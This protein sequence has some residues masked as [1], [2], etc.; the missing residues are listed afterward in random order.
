MAE[1]ELPYYESD[2]DDEIEVYNAPY[3]EG[4][5]EL[6]FQDGSQV[7][8]Y[9]SDAFDAD[10]SPTVEYEQGTTEEYHIM[11]PASMTRLLHLPRKI[12]V[13]QKLLMKQKQCFIKVPLRIRINQRM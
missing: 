10:S 6:E 1:L 11:N 8:I 2:K 13:L 3:M 12:I 9:D 4:G 7:P 5:N